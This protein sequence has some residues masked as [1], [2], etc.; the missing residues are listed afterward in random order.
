MKRYVYALCLMVSVAGISSCSKNND[1]A[2][3][4]P[5]VGKWELERVRISGLVAPYNGDNGDRQINKTVLSELI[6][7]KNDNTVSGR[8]QQN[9]SI[10]D[11]VGTWTFSNNELS[12]KDDKGNE[13]KYTL[14]STAEPLKLLTPLTAVSDSATNPTTKKRELVKYNIQFVYEK[15]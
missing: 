7:V 9:G 2:P 12:V 3:D 4:P 1:P 6:T 5:V 13:D 10:L 15:K 8:Y 11:Y 14:D